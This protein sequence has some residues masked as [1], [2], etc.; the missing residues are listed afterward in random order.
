[1]HFYFPN[2]TLAFYLLFYYLLII[3]LSTDL[4]IFLFTILCFKLQVNGLMLKW[5]KLEIAQISINVK[6]QQPARTAYKN[7]Q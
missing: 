6:I 1:M 3:I 7:T 5:Q 2:F 4:L